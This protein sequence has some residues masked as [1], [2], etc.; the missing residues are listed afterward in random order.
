MTDEFTEIYT[1]LMNAYKK[2]GRIGR[3]KPY[4]ADHANKI[5]WIV[6]NKIINKNKENKNKSN[7]TSR[8]LCQG[9]EPLTDS[10]TCCQLK[11]FPTNN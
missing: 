5:A 11:L 6:A 2:T 9:V 3:T 1:N 4:N 10:P 8:H 7:T